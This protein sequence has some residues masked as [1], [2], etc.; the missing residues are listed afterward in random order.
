M[1]KIHL[2]LRGDKTLCGKI[3]TSVDCVKTLM[4]WNMAPAKC[5]SCDE[6]LK[7]K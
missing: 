7:I 3:A 2:V 5:K 6:K 4:G 1:S